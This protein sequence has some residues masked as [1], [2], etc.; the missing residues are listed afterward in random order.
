M[1]SIEVIVMAGGMGSRMG[2][3]TEQKQKCLMEIDGTPA[4]GHIIDNLQTAF[5]SKIDLKVG[6]SYRQEDVKEFVDRYISEGINVSYIPHLRGS[7]LYGAYKSMEGSVK[8]LFVGTPGDVIVEPNAYTEALKVFENKGVPLVT[9]LSPKLDEVDSHGAG[10]IK[11]GIII[12]F[13]MPKSP[14]IKSYHL[15]DVMVYASAAEPFFN[16]LSRYDSETGGMSPVFVKGMSDGLLFGGAFYD[17]PWIHL[18]DKRDLIKTMK[19]DTNPPIS[20][21]AADK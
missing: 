3:L 8:G 18:A 11:D 7:E 5:G 9:T 14:N 19:K 12:E 16:L 10:S 1:K 21:F 15:R 20:V 13:L 4:L 2:S 17:R 6:V